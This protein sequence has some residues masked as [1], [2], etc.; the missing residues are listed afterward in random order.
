MR[1]TVAVETGLALL[2]AFFFA[3]YQ[4]VHADHSGVVH[5]HFFSSHVPHAAHDAGA[6]VN[7]EDDDDDDHSHA[8]SIDT[9]TIVLPGGIH[10][11]EPAKAPI[12]PIT[13]TETFAPVAQVEQRTHD[14]PS[15]DHSTPRAP[16]L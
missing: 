14:P 2:L 1:R 13:L 6:G 10:L 11:S 4:H 16:P 7:I 9:F 15:I 8:S 3:P 5:S 12:A